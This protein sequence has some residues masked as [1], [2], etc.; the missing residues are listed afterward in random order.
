MIPAFTLAAGTLAL[1]ANSWV[2]AAGRLSSLALSVA[3]ITPALLA[4]AAGIGA[5]L[6]SLARLTR[7]TLWFC[8]S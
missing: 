8:R 3:V 5:A 4:S 7:W 2:A 1:A 6:P